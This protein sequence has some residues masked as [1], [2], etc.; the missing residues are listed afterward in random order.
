MLDLSC[1]FPALLFESTWYTFGTLSSLRFSIGTVY[2]WRIIFLK[3]WTVSSSFFYVGYLVLLIERYWQS[4]DQKNDRYNAYLIGI[5]HFRICS[6]V[7]PF[8]CIV[9]ARY[10]NLAL[11][12]NPSH[13]LHMC[14]VYCTS[15]YCERLYN[16]LTYCNSI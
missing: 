14:M 10:N 7:F 8:G 15:L 12:Q 9:F 13:T 5:H 1:V 11:M 3:K 6:W 16:L 2:G 4:Y